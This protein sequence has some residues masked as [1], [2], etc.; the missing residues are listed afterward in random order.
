M[1]LNK[2]VRITSLGSQQLFPAITCYSVMVGL[3]PT[4]IE[5]DRFR[6]ALRHVSVSPLHDRHDRLL[7]S[8][9]RRLW[10]ACPRTWL[11]QSHEGREYPGATEEQGQR[12]K[13]SRN[14]LTSVLPAS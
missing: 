7:P 6:A 12:L 13:P 4:Y 8:R 3:P 2:S 5:P 14:Q 1:N 9:S 11:Q 10:C